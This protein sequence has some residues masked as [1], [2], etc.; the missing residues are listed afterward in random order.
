MRAMS[1]LGR[2]GPLGPFLLAALASAAEPPWQSNAKGLCEGPLCSLVLRVEIGKTLDLYAPGGS[3]DTGWGTLGPA[4][5]PLGSIGLP[6]TLAV[7]NVER[8]GD[9][10]HSKAVVTLEGGAKLTLYASM[11]SPGIVVETS[12]DKLRLFAGQHERFVTF[13]DKGKMRIHGHMGGN[14]APKATIT[15]AHIAVPQDKAIQ[16]FATSGPVPAPQADKA[17]ALSWW[18]KSSHFIRTEWPITGHGSHQ[19]GHLADCPLLLVFD[20]AP[21]SLSAVAEGG[22]DVTFARSGHRIAI[23]PILGASMTSAELTA[24]WMTALPDDV[25]SRCRKVLPFA[26]QYPLSAREKFEY[27]VQATG[28]WLFEE[29]LTF[30]AVGEGGRKLAVLPPIV[31]LAGLS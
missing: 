29:R 4:D 26:R 31:A 10:S 19:D 12:T 9:W 30:L 5:I 20:E 2:L 21:A 13:D 15:P 14:L 8:T 27:D 3:C 7:T 23:L 11:L 17:W 24:K 22:L 16:A 1:P 6:S 18:A 25:A 28:F